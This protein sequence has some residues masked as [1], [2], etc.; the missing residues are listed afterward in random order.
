MRTGADGIA[1]NETDD[2]VARHPLT[3]R[4]TPR[5]ALFPEL[6]WGTRRQ[7]SPKFSHYGWERRFPFR[8]CYDPGSHFGILPLPDKCYRKKILLLYRGRVGS[9]SA[10]KPR[11][12]ATHPHPPPQREGK[13]L[14]ALSLLSNHDGIY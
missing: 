12:S 7:R 2:F 5:G 9:G 14:L 13:Y 11:S 3:F 1:K 4:L 10:S 6:C 8:K